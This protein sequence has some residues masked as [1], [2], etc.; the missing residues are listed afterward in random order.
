M[1]FTPS[2]IITTILL[3]SGVV[4]ARPT[5]YLNE[6]EL[7]PSLA[8]GMKVNNFLCR[9]RFNWTPRCP[10]KYSFPD[11]YCDYGGASTSGALATHEQANA[12]LVGL[13][14]AAVGAIVVLG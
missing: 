11:F 3:S 1:R 4:S 13:A 10:C 6:S 9:D 2:S 12:Q 5:D 7:N 8:G 14:A